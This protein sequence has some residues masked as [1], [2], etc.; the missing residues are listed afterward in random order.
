MEQT[1]YSIRRLYASMDALYAKSSAF[2]VS[3]PYTMVNIYG[4]SDWRRQLFPTKVP[5][6]T[7]T[8]YHRLQMLQ[9]ILLESHIKQN[10][11]NIQVQLYF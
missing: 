11:V 5:I 8:S 6:M 1:V 3:D 9:L 10:H 2:P 7:S 4:G